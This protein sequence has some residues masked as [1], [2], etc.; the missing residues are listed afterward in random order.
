MTHID[1]IRAAV[2]AQ[3][4]IDQIQRA[5][6]EKQIPSKRQEQIS[7]TKLRIAK[8]RFDAAARSL[9]LEAIVRLHECAAWWREVELSY[10]WFRPLIAFSNTAASDELSAISHAAE[11]AIDYALSALESEVPN[12]DEG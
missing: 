7:R 2:E 5:L 11:R 10:S 1:R 12:A 3:K 9:P 6:Q 8:Y 4:F